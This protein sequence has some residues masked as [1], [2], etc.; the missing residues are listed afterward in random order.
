MWFWDVWLVELDMDI[1]GK[2][3]CIVKR[4]SLGIEMGRERES[5]N[6]SVF[7]YVYV[8]ILSKKGREGYFR[9]RALFE[10]EDVSTIFFSV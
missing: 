7:I 6:L 3:I 5:D 2:E 10:R 1:F 4:F 9:F 8:F